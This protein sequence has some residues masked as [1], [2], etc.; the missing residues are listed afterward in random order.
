MLMTEDLKIILDAIHSMDESLNAKIDQVHDALMQEMNAF[1]CSTQK[2]LLNA[3][4]IANDNYF[5]LWNR[6]YRIEMLHYEKKLEDFR[7]DDLQRNLESL[8]KKLKMA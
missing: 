8:K 7:K 6:L 5:D 1:R 3:K 2:E 4:R